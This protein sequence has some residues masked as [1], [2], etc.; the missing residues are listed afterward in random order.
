MQVDANF[1]IIPDTYDTILGEYTSLFQDVF[2]NATS[3]DDPT[4]VIGSIAARLDRQ[5][6][7]ALQVLWNS[8]NANTASGLGQDILSNTV[9]NL[10]RK[11]LTPSSAV[12][13]FTVQNLLSYCDVQ[14][15]VTVS[16]PQTIPITWVVS[17][18]VSPS[19]TYKPLAALAI[20]LS[21][22]YTIRVFS[23]D[24]TTVIPAAAFNAGTAVSGITFN[25][26]IN[27]SAGIL[28]HITIPADWAITSSILNPSP[29]YTPR[30]SYIFNTNGVHSILVY[31]DDIIKNIFPGQLNTFT[32]INN[33][34]PTPQTMVVP[35]SVT[36]PTQ[37]RLGKPEESDA[38]F[39]ARR[40]YYLNVKGQTYY[41]L[42]KAIL[43][44]N[45]PSLNSLFIWEQNS[46]TYNTSMAII[47]IS[48]VVTS[49]SVVIPVGWTVLTSLGS[50]PSPAYKTLQAFSFTVT[51]DYYIPVF[52]TDVTTVVGIGQFIS[53]AAISGVTFVGNSEPA[54]LNAIIGLGQRG[55]IVY[56]EYPTDISGNFDIQD[57]YLQQIASACFEYHP[58]GTNFYGGGSGQTTFNLQ[59][60]YSGY[61]SSVILTPLQIDQ[62]TVV[63]NLVYN[64][65]PKD[66][67]YS[68][69]VFPIDTYLSGQLKQDLLNI[70][71]AYFSSKTLPTDMVY[72][73]S[74]LSE[75]ILK[76]YNGIVSLGTGTTAF[77]FGTISPSVTGKVYLKRPIG[78][79]FNLTLSNFTFLAINKDTI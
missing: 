16:A 13:N 20:P 11:S 51:G 55:Y 10:F 32:Q 69:G 44:L 33:D 5:N 57:V 25:S 17:G 40:R 71:N 78:Y 48:V 41:G 43:D 54:I 56:L 38:S 18:T 19:P 73:I 9:L 35:N 62:A 46:E 61:T 60:P 4:Y 66:S 42:E 74:E 14:I 45:I 58:L 50:P 3:P 1:G 27:L 28:G 34:N 67:G 7:L 8:I 36:N 12:V 24:I 21:G 52:S 63:L 59:T 70:I 72:S 2:P 76:S 77:T 22:T 23:T 49:G 53:G 15:D 26:V 30:Q 64:I 31:S 47:K 37:N 39:A 6:E 75:I 79:R 65:D 29:T 68:N